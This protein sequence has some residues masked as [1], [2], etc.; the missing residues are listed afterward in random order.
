MKTK[1]L[2]LLFTLISFGVQAQKTYVLLTGV[3]NYGTKDNNLHNSTKDVK[4]LKTI[5]E[6]QKAIV[7]VLTGK[8]VTRD[9]LEKKLNAIVQL[10]KPED[11]IIFFFS[12]HG[13]I[14]GFVAYGPDIISY[15]YLTDIFSKAKTRNVF[16]F[17]DACMSGSSAA[18]AV[19]GET[20][21]RYIFN[22][23]ITF[24]SSSRILEQSIEN[25]W[26]GHGFFTQALLKAL[27]GKADVNQ[28]RNI[29]L[30]ELFN[31]IYND[32]TARTNK[33]EK[34]Q[35]PQLIGPSSLY[36]TIITSW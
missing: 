20:E 19:E 4:S 35:H 24:V 34:T 28:D 7:G 14:G 2:I 21:D 18:S 22:K 36:E 3:S 32:V 9:N 23:N 15:S 5:F 13:M 10:A 30:M 29:T 16:C 12:G 17:I 1:V 11:K 26:V 27:R 8:N 31:Y 25:D 33:G 6:S